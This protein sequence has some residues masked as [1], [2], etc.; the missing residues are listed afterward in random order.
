MVEKIIDIMINRNVIDFREKEIYYYGLFVLLFNVIILIS[1][2][3]VGYMCGKLYD[4]IMFLVFFMP[5][6][7]YIGGY[8]CKTPQKC[9]IVSNLVFLLSIFSVHIFENFFYLVII[10]QIIMLI[11]KS[12]IGYIKIEYYQILLVCYLIY[13]ILGTVYPMLGKYITLSLLLNDLLSL[14]E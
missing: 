6:R 5:L 8:H 4:A 14:I 2:I 3:F 13:L 9:F 10:P 11:Y 12:K 1:F 7:L